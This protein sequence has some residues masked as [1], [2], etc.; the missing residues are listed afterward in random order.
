MERIER[1]FRD[2]K[3]CEM[4]TRTV[5]IETESLFVNALNNQSISLKTSQKIGEIFKK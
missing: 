5:G 2:A 1:Y 3:T 4:E